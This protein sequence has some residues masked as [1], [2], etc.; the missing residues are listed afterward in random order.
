MQTASVA[1]DA[2]RTWLRAVVWAGALSLVLSGVLQAVFPRQMGT[3]PP[4]FRTPVLALELARAPSE[5]E[6]MF[7]PAG[8]A[9]RAQWV[10]QADR[11]NQLD[12]A[13]IP[14][15]CFFLFACARAFAAARV[16][17]VRIVLGLCVLAGLGDAVENIFLFS[18]TA[19]LGGEY[20]GDVMG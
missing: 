6:A 15:Y 10:A 19:H 17:V 16:R 5:L 12:Y 13:F 11:G 8:S 7:G 2:T 3:L 4:G 18:I 9:Q 20:A 1:S 14:V